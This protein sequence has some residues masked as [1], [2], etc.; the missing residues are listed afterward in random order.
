MNSRVSWSVDGI[1]P[2]VRE[3]AEA[4]ARRAGMSLN[5]WL[6]S[7]LGESARPNF[8]GAYDQ[9][10]DPRAQH[11]PGPGQGPSQER[12]DVADIHQRLDAITQQ[13]E[14][15]SKPAPRQDPSRQDASRPDMSR[16]QGVAR[17]LNDAISRL[18]ARL[19][20]ISKPQSQAPR[21]APIE[22]RQRQADAVE[23]AAAQV[24]R[25][26]PPLS[27]ASFD[28]AVAEITAR[29]SELDGFV[30]R[31]MPPRAAPSIAPPAAP[32][33]PTM[34]PPTP[35]Y[36][37]PPPQPGPDFSSLERH[38]LKITSQIESLQRPDN[39]EQAINA[40]RSELAEIRH[41]ITEAMPRRAIESIENE[42]RSLHRRIDE[43]RSSGTDGQ[44]LSGIEHALSDIKQVLRTLTP[45]EQLTGY[46][47]AIRNLGAKLDLILRANDDPSTVR[48]LEDAIA[49]L[50]AIVSNVA[51][52]EAL[53]RLSEDVQLLSSKV[54]QVTRVSSGPGDSF[55]VL[56]QRIAALTAALE[57]RE[58]PQP[59]ES[60]EHLEAAIRALSD[61]FD[62]MQVG[63]DS[64]STFAHLEQRVS[65]LLE[66]IEAT[67]DSRNGNLSRVEDGL[68]DILRH[69]E[70]QQATYSALAESR[71]SAPSADSGVVD[72]V[73]REL[74]DIRFSQA[75]TTRT[76]QDSL[77]AVHNALGHVVDRLS[78]IEGDL[79]AVRT[80]PPPAASQ[81]IMTM[82]MAMPEASSTEPAPM[83]REARPQ[84]APKYDPKPELQNPAAAQQAP[85]SAFAAAPRE[86][87]AAATPA[88]PPPVPTAPQ[89]T[90][91][92]PPRA[93]SEI[94]QPHTAPA[95]A[96]LAPE[97]PPDHPLEPGTR[98]GGRVATPS[99]RI[100]AS[101]SAISEIAAAPK[102][103]VSSSSFIAAARRA[104]QAAAAQPEK[105][106]RGAK[107]ATKSAAK[108]ANA[109]RAKDNGQEGGSTI[110]AKIRSLLVGASVVVIVLGTFKMAMN[111]LDGGN[112]PPA[113]QA[114]E[115]SSSAP[116]PQAP[117]VESKPAAPE[118]VTPSM[119]SPTPIGKQSLNTAAPAP[120]AGSASTAS[121]EIPPAPAVPPAP[122]AN[123]DI[124]GAL[125]GT[126]RARLGLVQVPP[127]EKLPDAIG[128]PVLRTAAMKGDAAA[129]FEIG[130]RFAEGKGVA[131]NY[132]EA[133]KWY[134]RAA[135]AGV[136]PATFRLG[137]LYEKGLGVKKD[138]DIARRYYTQAAERG[139]AKAMHNLAVL[140]ADGGGRGANYKSA[141]QWFRKAADR[142]VADSQFN[143]GILYAR[144]IGVEQNLAESYKWFSLAAAQGD[145]DASGKRDDVAKR[146]DPQ[147]LAA[148]KLAIQ[149][150]SAEPQP[151]DAVNV[152]APAGGWDSAPQATAKPMPKPVATKKSA[153]AAH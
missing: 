29:Q 18:D 47:E 129:A 68:H 54:D 152:A 53:A 56:E 40:F 79:R 5:D 15:I 133:A 52:N 115:D 100:A 95:R 101:E 147:S 119:T 151:D 110:T 32:F 102:E 51:S 57:T 74:S 122:A 105:P 14:R 58:R 31:P 92:V 84:Q 148:A 99:E 24:Y 80:A 11:M 3:R 150:F 137:T 60:S 130:L 50:R 19:S 111:L 69:L 6:N 37:P 131:T 83:A 146:L 10:P 107:S 35:V 75:E 34:A 81:P 116:A 125:T 36:A 46:D 89:A 23:R 136:V 49:A 97:L 65:Y 48:Q 134:D 124:T 38:L 12:R 113:P 82:P 67:S 28:V 139:N 85:Q 41:A 142:G 153:S 44:V 25:N 112:A 135:Q 108:A 126:S 109:V 16:E 73:K 94:L 22:S 106:A 59:S 66:R 26:S 104:A 39:T 27:P 62:R 91:P 43:T 77:E 78:M 149:T 87:H 8:R 71:S 42:I 63:N 128:G 144:G 30:P 123:S 55:A 127:S 13:I 117:P 17:Q 143:L 61:R 90:P 120:V 7:T 33:A 132:D 140:D 121:V 96:A 114:M 145:A 141:A 76:T 118:Q 21:P 9:R 98:P 72:I 1:D 88:A 93:I 64:A 70:R 4:A 20:Q 45:A 103:P 2:S 138:A 86:F